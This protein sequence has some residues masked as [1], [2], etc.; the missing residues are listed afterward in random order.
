MMVARATH[1]FR[2]PRNKQVG[3]FKRINYEFAITYLIRLDQKETFSKEIRIAKRN[4]RALIGTLVTIWDNEVNFLRIDGRIQAWKTDSLINSK[5]SLQNR[6]WGYAVNVTIFTKKILDYRG[7]KYNKK[8]CASMSNLLQT[9]NADLNTT[10]GIF[11]NKSNDT[12]PTV[13]QNWH[14]LCWTSH[15]KV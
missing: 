11:A 7:R 1:N 2:F 5:C 4:G 3:N 14:R 10:N 9:K 15:D 8:C 6:A 12:K 13:C